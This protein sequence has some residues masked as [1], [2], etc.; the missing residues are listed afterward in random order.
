[1]KKI[2]AFIMHVYAFFSAPFN[3]NF[4]KEVENY[5]QIMKHAG[6]SNFDDYDGENL[7]ENLDE[8][9]EDQ[10]Q[11]HLDDFVRKG[12]SRANASRM[13]STRMQG[14][15]GSRWSNYVKNKPSSSLVG[16]RSL[17]GS[18]AQFAIKINRLN[19]GAATMPS[20]PIALFGTIHKY[21]NYNI[22]NSMI[23]SGWSLDNV[24]FDQTQGYVQFVY[25]TGGGTSGSYI[26][27]SCDQISYNSLLNALATDSFR[28]SFI[29]YEVNPADV[30][31]FSNDAKVM[32]KTSF[33][34]FAENPL[35]V[36]NNRDPKN[37]QNGII[38]IPNP[39]DIDKDTAV[40][41]I[42]K[43]TLTQAISLSFNV[44]KFYRQ[45]RKMLS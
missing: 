18:V 42:I 30:S 39:I 3:F 23:P 6:L 41:F 27:V 7:D 13:A 35:P 36:S 40:V 29:R 34:Q 19:Y 5:N 22:I 21:S 2:L 43:P 31:Q 15:Y 45:D 26:Q 16:G 32:K 24:I 12:N 17:R 9:L 38:D 1:M 25:T 44:A 28:T 8:N 11:E 37:Y 4:D 14:K 33:G 10:F 20:L